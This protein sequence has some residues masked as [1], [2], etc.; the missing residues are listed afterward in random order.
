MALAPDLACGLGPSEAAVFVSAVF[1]GA[2]FVGA[3]FVGA[4][5]VGAVFAIAGTSAVTAFCFGVDTAFIGTS[6]VTGA[7]FTAAPVDGAAARVP[8]EPLVGAGFGSGWEEAFNG[9][10][11][12]VFA[13][14]S[15]L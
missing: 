4:V 6:L 7:D 5:F 14:A 10:A 8:T 11:F 2:G 15:L 9:A 12:W 13:T 3:G 1:A